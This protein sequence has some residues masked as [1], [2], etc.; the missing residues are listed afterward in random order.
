M[1]RRT[2]S[3]F[4]IKYICKE[5]NVLLFLKRIEREWYND[6][7]VIDDELNPFSTVSEEY[8]KK[9]EQ[10]LEQRRKTRM[11]AQQ[12]QINQV[13]LGFLFLI[14][15]LMS[16]RLQDIEKWETNRMIQ[17]GVVTK[18]N[19]DQ[20]FDDESESRVHLLVTNLVPPFLDGRIRFTR[21]C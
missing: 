4:S 10:A 17:S 5:N 7:D 9:K 19:I 2:K 1:G 18:V 14:V 15:D 3:K 6:E 12:R 8:T 13:S 21:Q 11:S 20:D 16:F